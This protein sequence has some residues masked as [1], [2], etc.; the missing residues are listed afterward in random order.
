MPFDAF[1]IL[2]MLLLSCELLQHCKFVLGWILVESI[3]SDQKKMMR[4]KY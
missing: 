1:V 2:L 4:K 3:L